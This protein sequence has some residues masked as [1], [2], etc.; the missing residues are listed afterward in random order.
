[1]ARHLADGRQVIRQEG[2]VVAILMLLGSPDPEVAEGA[3]R[4]LSEM[5]QDSKSASIIHAQGGLQKL[6]ALVRSNHSG[7]QAAAAHCLGRCM[8]DPACLKAMDGQFA[9]GMH[10]LIRLLYK[11][12]PSLQACILI[13]YSYLLF[14]PVRPVVNF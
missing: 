9:G 7:M 11:P 8:H 6:F 14:K 3:A 4:A 13:A 5:S 1:V 2:G 12:Q 10:V